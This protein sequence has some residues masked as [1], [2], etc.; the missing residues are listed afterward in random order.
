[1]VATQRWFTAFRHLR[2]ALM[3]I[4]AAS[5][6]VVSPAGAKPVAPGRPSP[7]A[8]AIAVEKVIIADSA[9]WVFK[10]YKLGSVRD[11]KVENADE[12]GVKIVSAN[13]SYT[14]YSDTWIKIVVEKNGGVRCI[15]YGDEFFTGCR[16][17]GDN[18]AI[19]LIAGAIESSA[20]TPRRDAAC[21]PGDILLNTGVGG[22]EYC[23]RP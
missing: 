14:A 11:V 5:L 22:R 17:V 1:M 9:S 8:L 21:P 7:N 15:E 12:P 19:G 6:L 20:T 13:Y 4:A 2:G 16:D 23:A 10:V 18:P 3:A